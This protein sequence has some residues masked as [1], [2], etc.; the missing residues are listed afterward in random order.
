[1]IITILLNDFQHI[2]E[3]FSYLKPFYILKWFIYYT[4][5]IGVQYSSNLAVTQPNVFMPWFMLVVLI[6]CPGALACRNRLSCSVREEIDPVLVLQWW[7]PLHWQSCGGCQGWTTTTACTLSG[8]QM[9]RPY[10]PA[11]IWV[12][13]NT[14]SAC[15][16]KHTVAHDDGE[17][18][19]AEWIT[20]HRALH[21]VVD[22]TTMV[23]SLMLVL[24]WVVN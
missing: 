11:C 12:W 24:S 1:M 14:F 23:L 3:W 5:T 7:W 16:H 22:H 20:E 13:K 17:P 6:Q 8:P 19:C 9:S 10:N 21:Q 18:W 15:K 4:A 2:F